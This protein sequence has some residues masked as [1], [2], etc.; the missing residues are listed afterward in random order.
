M[1]EVV[2]VIFA[3]AGLVF[4][5]IC[6]ASST[7]FGWSGSKTSATMAL[8]AITIL[9]LTASVNYQAGIIP[10]KVASEIA[11]DI[12]KG[13]RP[14]GYDQTFT[15]YS[16]ITFPAF[17]LTDSWLSSI[18]ASIGAWASAIYLLYD[19]LGSRFRLF[20]F[21]PAILNFSIFALR[22][23]VFGILLGATTYEMTREDRLRPIRI[24]LPFVCL[25]VTRPE[26]AIAI[27][28]A[29]AF[30]R[31]R[32]TDR[33]SYIRPVKLAALFG[34]AVAATQ[35]IPR[36]LGFRQ[37]FGFFSFPSR[38]L[39]F[40]EDR[41]TRNEDVEQAASN[42]NILRGALARM[43]FPIRF[44]LQLCAFFVLPFPFEI[45]S[46]ALALAF[47]DSLVFITMTKRVWSLSSERHRTLVISYIASVSFFAA[48]Y[49]NL[50][51]LRMPVYF[52][53]MAIVVASNRREY[54]I[55][56]T[57]KPTKE[58]KANYAS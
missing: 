8:S 11:Y 54:L 42:S 1:I 31:Y 20:L 37:S 38:L 2:C 55:D 44:P 35:I 12:F 13:D 17:A 26:S 50:L 47:L 30:S 34:G 36:A 52:M 27:L 25:A 23:T 33:S 51:R 46:F 41:A 15:V 24:F 16:L 10:Q 9:S 18:G 28:G 19:K 57:A 21:A 53:F 58:V 39:A 29:F 7:L 49:G 48:N 14:W 40:F 22:D 4:L 32:A 3:S 56:R 43:P 6:V 45:R 5:S